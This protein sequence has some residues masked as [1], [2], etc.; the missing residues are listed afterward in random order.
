MEII[1]VDRSGVTEAARLFDRYRQFYQCAPDIALA[2][3]FIT[4]RVENDESVIF[5]ACNGDVGMGF[6]QLYPSFCSV[7]AI[8][9]FILYDLYVEPEV[10]QSGLGKQLMEHASAFAKGQGAGRVDLLTDNDNLVGQGLYEKL[11][12][13]RTNE[14]YYAYS[15]KL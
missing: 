4:E 13:V 10:R 12:Y 8:K 7:E 6:V 9:I 1:R 15:L 2:T 11:G 3:A 5:M 14:N